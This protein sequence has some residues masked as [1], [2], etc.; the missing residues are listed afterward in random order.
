MSKIGKSVAAMSVASCES[1]VRSIIVVSVGEGARVGGAR[2][3]RAGVGV[4]VDVSVGDGRVVLVAV[5]NRVGVSGWRMASCG[6]G[7]SEG[8]G[9]GVLEGRGVAD[10]AGVGVGLKKTTYAPMA[11]AITTTSPMPIMAAMA[12]P[13]T[14]AGAMPVDSF[15]DVRVGEAAGGVCM[16]VTVMLSCPPRCRASSTSAST[17]ACGVL[18]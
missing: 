4:E 10:G 12:V 6:V 15:F 2:V 8:N 3:V 11:A 9:M 1:R 16:A 7:V 17:A 13:P 14:S 5:G 18:P